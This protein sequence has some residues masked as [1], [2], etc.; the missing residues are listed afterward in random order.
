MP[1][2]AHL[3]LLLRVL[4]PLRPVAASVPIIEAHSHY[5]TERVEAILL[6]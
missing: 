1:T 6:G 3:L 5:S 2:P 4:S